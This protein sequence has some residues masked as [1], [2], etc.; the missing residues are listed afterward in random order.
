MRP[1]FR[2]RVKHYSQCLVWAKNNGNNSGIGERPPNHHTLCH[3]QAW[4]E[5]CRANVGEGPCAGRGPAQIL[6]VNN[7]LLESCW[8]DNVYA[9]LILL[10]FIYLIK[11]DSSC[12]PPLSIFS[13]YVTFEIKSKL[14]LSIFSIHQDTTLYFFQKPSTFCSVAL[15]GR[16][17]SW[18]GEGKQIKAASWG[19][20]VLELKLMT[21]SLSF[22][23]LI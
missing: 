4:S 18:E 12:P 19:L 2:Y 23:F 8:S 1:S 3:L 6:H 21:V 14:F 20:L 5:S 10:F 7:G 9:S 22:E 17:S 16:C 11:S 15:P 13:Y